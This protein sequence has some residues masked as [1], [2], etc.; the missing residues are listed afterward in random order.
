MLH[1]LF[2]NMFN[3]KADTQ[4]LKGKN[5]QSPIFKWFFSYR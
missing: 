5:T 4:T 3:T 2:D 1:S